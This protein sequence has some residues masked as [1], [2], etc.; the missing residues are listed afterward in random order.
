MFNIGQRN[1]HPSLTA[2]GLRAVF[3]SDAESNLQVS[4]GHL[5]R[6]L[7]ESTRSTLSK[8]W[9]LPVP[10]NINTS[11]D[12]GSPSFFDD[13]LSLSFTLTDESCNKDIYISSRPDFSSPW[14][15]P[16]SI[17][18]RINSAALENQP[19]LS[20]DGK[21]LVFGSDRPGGFG[22][23]DLYY[24]TLSANG[25]WSEPANLGP[26]INSDGFEQSPFLSYDGTELYFRS[27]GSRETD[28]LGF[29]LYVAQ[30]VP[31]PSSA[32][33][34]LCGISAMIGLIRRR[35]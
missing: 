33:I 17:S 14:S 8:P 20:D 26:S 18:E 28:I 2:D 22:N 3:M 23:Q 35:S 27:G 32:A 9:T 7:Y 6:D 5:G 29:D 13:G 24:S 31:E 15:T 11:L 1:D 34:S 12:E 19:H 21:L 30:V 16:E 10:L 25:Q 4:P